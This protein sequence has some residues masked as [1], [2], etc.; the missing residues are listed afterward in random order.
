MLSNRLIDPGLRTAEVLGGQRSFGFYDVASHVTEEEASQRPRF[1]A[2]R[3]SPQ[4]LGRASD[5]CTWGHTHRRPGS[6]RPSAGG[7]GHLQMI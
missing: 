2:H 4:G 6:R 3:V 7:L 5:W 1:R